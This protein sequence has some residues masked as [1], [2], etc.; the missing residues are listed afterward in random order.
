MTDW[1]AVAPSGE[2][3]S[4]LMAVIGPN[5]SG[6]T[7]LIKPLS[8]LSW[9]VCH[10]FQHPPDAGIPVFPYI[11]APNEPVEFECT[12]D[13]DGRLWRYVLRCT[14]DRVLYEALY[15]RRERFGYV[16]V[17]EWRDDEKCYVVKQQDFGLASQEA[18]KVRPNVSLISWAAQFDVPIAKRLMSPYVVTN[19]G[20]AGRLP[21]WHGTVNVAARHFADK[22]AQRALMNRLLSQWDLGLS[23]VE[24]EEISQVNADGS[25]SRKEWIPFGTHKGRDDDLWSIPFTMESS[26]TQG[27]FVLLSRLLQALEIGG[28]A[29]IDE[30]ENDLHPHMLDPILSLFADRKTNPHDAQL[31]FTCHAPEVLNL[32]EKSQVMLV[33]KNEHCES[34]ASRMDAVDG[35]RNDD[36]FYAKYMAGAYGAVPNL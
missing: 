21:M 9:F 1:I 22:Q 6:K 34:C 12:L 7:S 4:K 14:P 33:E 5:G 29:V 13:F 31:I 15:Q 26:G 20:S 36:N 30:F 27:A 11:S 35:I 28:L 2:R 3:V 23:G 24:L 32:V 19:I 10:S 18:R 8:F 17:R 25:E 16:F